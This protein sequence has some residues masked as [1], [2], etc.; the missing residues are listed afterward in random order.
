MKIRDR[1]LRLSHAKPVDGT[2][3]KTMD[4]GKIKWG[5]KLKEVS[6]PG[7]KSHEGGDKA[8]RKAS[9][10]SYQGL[11]ASKSGV[12]KKAKVN[13]RP[14]S[15]RKQGKTKTKESGPSAQLAKKRKLDGSTPE[16]TRKSKKAR[17]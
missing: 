14:S 13:Q 5:P 6:T 4:A 17:K 7:S 10:L 16:N 8:K 3:K 9:A 15:E 1:I 12:V 2:P 11:R